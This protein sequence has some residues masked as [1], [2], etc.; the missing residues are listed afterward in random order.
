MQQHKQHHQVRRPAVHVPDD[1]AGRDDILQIFHDV[2][3][4][5]GAG[6]VIE[7]QQHT[8]GDQ[9]QEEVKRDQSQPERVGS[10]Q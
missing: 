5:L 6:H 4:L 1:Q 8:G 3:R 9:D 10:A 2:V 7:H